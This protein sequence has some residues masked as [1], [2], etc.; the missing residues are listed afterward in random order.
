MVVRVGD[1]VRLNGGSGLWDFLLES[2][3]GWLR[4]GLAGIG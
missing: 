3:G 2:D 4:L 1:D